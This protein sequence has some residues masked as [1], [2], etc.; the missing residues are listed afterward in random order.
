MCHSDIGKSFQ[1]RM[2]FKY[3]YY[4]ET[5]QLKWVRVYRCKQFVGMITMY[6]PETVMFSLFLFFFSFS[7]SM[8]IMH[9]CII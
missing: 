7:H 1:I 5:D 6:I 3:S 9:L 8:F 2:I 4:D